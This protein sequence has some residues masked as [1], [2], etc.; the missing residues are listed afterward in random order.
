MWWDPPPFWNSGR[1]WDL[2]LD[3]RSH[4][5]LLPLAPC[6]LGPPHLTRPRF[7]RLSGDKI[8]LM[9]SPS[10]PPRWRLWV[11]LVKHDGMVPRF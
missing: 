2:S 9:R 1:R 6:N 11:V 4:Q 7:P 5:P 3:L 10:L 8:C